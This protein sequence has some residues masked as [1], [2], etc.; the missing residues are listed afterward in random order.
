V[1]HDTEKDSAQFGSLES[2]STL[3]TS[4]NFPLGPSVL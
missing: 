4:G 3:P 1:I 2:G